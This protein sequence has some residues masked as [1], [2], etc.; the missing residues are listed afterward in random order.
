MFSGKFSTGVEL[1]H[2]LMGNSL[3]GRIAYFGAACDSNYGFGVLVT[4][5]RTLTSLGATLVWY[6]VFGMHELGHNLGSGNTHDIGDYNP[7]V[8]SCVD[9]SNNFQVFPVTTGSGT[10]MS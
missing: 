1:Y 2:S 9:R 5:A 10:I 6:A 8:D 7:V 3:G 4:M